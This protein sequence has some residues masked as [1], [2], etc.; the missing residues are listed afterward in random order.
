MS[1]WEKRP[2]LSQAQQAYAA[3]DAW[4][5]WE[6]YASC[7]GLPSQTNRSLAARRATDFFASPAAV[8]AANARRTAWLANSPGGRPR[9]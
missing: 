9:R 5:C 8:E 6:A 3:T 7:V 2:A 4:V 1:D